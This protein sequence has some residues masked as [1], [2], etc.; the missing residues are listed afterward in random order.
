MAKGHPEQRLPNKIQVSVNYPAWH[1]ARIRFSGAP[2][3]WETENILPLR[4]VT[5]STW[6]SAFGHPDNLRLRLF[7][8]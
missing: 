7:Y 8:F 5:K 6:Q 2:Q 3:G 1:A 4:Q